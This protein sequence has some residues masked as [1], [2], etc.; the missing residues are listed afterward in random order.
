MR[1]A[2]TAWVSCFLAACASTATITMSDGTVVETEIVE[3]DETSITVEDKGER[4]TIARTAIADIDHPGN[5]AL[6]AGIL[7]LA[8]GVATAALATSKS[9]NKAVSL[10][11]YTPAVVGLGLSIYGGATYARSKMA[12]GTPVEAP[13]SLRLLPVFQASSGRSFAGLNAAMLF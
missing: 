8:G 12:A 9:D 2:W 4:Q 11:A 1:L 7:L 5:V 13:L 6:T 3:S 10:G